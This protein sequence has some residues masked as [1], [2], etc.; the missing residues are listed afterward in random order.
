MRTGN[1]KAKDDT[2]DL[3]E[4]GLNIFKI[5]CMTFKKNTNVCYLKLKCCL[6]FIKELEWSF[7]MNNAFSEIDLISFSR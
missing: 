3:E 4:I 5:N 1:G 7:I 6:L 2:V